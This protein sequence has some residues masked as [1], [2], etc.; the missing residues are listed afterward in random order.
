MQR[1]QPKT[2]GDLP[3][4]RWGRTF[5]SPQ[6]GLKKS[7]CSFAESSCRLDVSRICCFLSPVK[8]TALILNQAVSIG[9]V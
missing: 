6:G 3:P 5:E 2:A 9:L 4:R 1:H 7:L 8:C